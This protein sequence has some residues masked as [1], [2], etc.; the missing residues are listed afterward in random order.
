MLITE[1]AKIELIGVHIVFMLI[2]EM[3]KKESTGGHIGLY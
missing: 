1:M 3:A 2:I